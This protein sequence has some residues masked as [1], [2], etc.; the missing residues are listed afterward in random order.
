VV[1]AGP[2]A[3]GGGLVAARHLTVAGARVVM[4]LSA[5]TE[6]FAPVPAKQLATGP[7]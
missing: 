3:N 1:L 2:G 4:A 6:Q 7:L 5:P